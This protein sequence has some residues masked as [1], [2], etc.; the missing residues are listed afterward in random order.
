MPRHPG[1]HGEVAG[2]VRRSEG[3]ARARAFVVVSV[4]KARQGRISRLMTG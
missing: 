3:K 2:S 1:P 4:G